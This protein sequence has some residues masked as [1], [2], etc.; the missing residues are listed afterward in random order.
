MTC[1]VSNTCYLA[2]VLLQW[3]STVCGCF[4]CFLNDVFSSQRSTHSCTPAIPL[5]SSLIP[6]SS[7]PLILHTDWGYTHTAAGLR[8]RS[9]ALHD[10]LKGLVLLRH[11]NNGH[12]GWSDHAVHK[13]PSPHH[14]HHLMKQSHANYLHWNRKDCELIN[15][16]PP[17]FTYQCL[18]VN[19]SKT[20]HNRGIV[21]VLKVQ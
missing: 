14:I 6:L 3:V 18:N 10:V 12:N 2:L 17:V 4:H 1:P 19:D 7:L 8:L 13:P 15:I 9:V 21:I 11:L 20:I 5:S 16:W